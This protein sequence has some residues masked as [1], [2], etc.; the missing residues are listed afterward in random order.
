MKIVRLEAE[1]VKR[2]KAVEIKPDGS[3]VIVGGRNAQGKQQP[4]SE[5]ILTPT[6]WRSIG[7]LAVGD[8]VIGSSGEATRVI[9]LHPQDERR[10]FRVTLA[11]GGTTRCG[12]EH[13][14]TVLTWITGKKKAGRRVCKTLTTAELLDKGL[15]RGHKQ[16][17]RWALPPLSSVVFADSGMNLPV[18]P[19][20]LGVVLGDG[21]IELGGYVTVTS[22]DQEIMQRLEV[23]SGCR[24]ERKNCQILGTAEWSRPLSHLG[25]AG[26][27][28]PEKFIPPGYLMAGIEERRLLLAGLLD[29]DGTHSSCWA[30]FATSSPQLAKDISAL[31]LGLGYLAS[32]TCQT[33]K[34]TYKGEK[35]VGLPAYIVRIKNNPCPF[36]L[37]RKRSKWR[38]NEMGKA[39]RFIDS[40]EQTRDEQSI[41][42][43]VDAG[44]GLYVT[45]DYILTH[46]SS[47]LDSIAMALG[48]EKMLPA[49]P[50]REGEDKARV[51]LDLDGMVVTRTFT[52][53]GSYLKVENADGATVK[54][55]QAMLDQLVGRLS[56]DPLEFSRMDKRRQ[57]ET[58]KA[59]VGL[60]FAA[61]DAEKKEAYDR[62]TEMNRE[63]K[64][65]QARIQAMPRHDD[66]PAEEVSIAMLMESLRAAQAVQ[67]ANAEIV[68][69]HDEARRD[70][71]RLCAQLA[72]R[73]EEMRRIQAAVKA[74]EKEIERSEAAVMHAAAQVTTIVEPDM[75]G[76]R[77][78]LAGAEDVNRKVR[79]NRSRSEAL[80]GLRKVQKDADRFSEQI[81][82]MDR[83]KAAALAAAK[84]PVEGLAFDE[85]GVTYRG[86]PFD[87]ASSAEQLR[88]SVGMGFALHRDLKVTLI[89][90]G[91]L[92]DEG[93][94][95]LIAD[96]AT[97]A[98]A[99]VW[100]ERVG[101]G[102]ECA[103]II[104][105]G[106]VKA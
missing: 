22:A 29:T 41:C 8:M 28:A 64:A 50:I 81:V 77:D 103:V 1:N 104:E 86:L 73:I 37:S 32:T 101:E 63:V 47:V 4:I 35:K 43:E 46:N 76:L 85:Q 17:R 71:I 42:I 88:V 34:Y 79:E 106:A 75:A 87:Q 9:A 70:H 90:D 58:L 12:P 16:S 105:D 100:L 95:K 10:T 66:A 44:D 61:Q 11:D 53:K 78:Q 51:V 3:L 6:G 96:M 99:Q 91:S 40:I 92:L 69:D 13:L 27:L 68:R 94:L 18:D 98:G 93:N 2:L 30:E 25:L 23:R 49:K 67:E 14:W 19:Y 65:L 15:W 56:F 45:N 89:R 39:Y 80:A 48:G 72:E 83:Q 24:F 60:D 97:A 102:A 26:K 33:K 54:S 84:F 55:P 82:E 20:A 52:E 62:R 38:P 5:P 74:L 7:E 21:H 36:L 57:L 31:A 59:L